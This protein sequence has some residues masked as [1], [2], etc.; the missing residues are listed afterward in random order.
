MDSERLSGKKVL[1]LE[2]DSFLH[3]LLANKMADLR[4]QGAEIFSALN[5]HDALRWMQ[6]STPDVI[7][8]D[9]IMPEMNGFDFL[10]SIRADDRF[11]KTQVVVLSNLNQDSD[12]KRARDLGVDHYYVKADFSLDDVM[13]VIVMLLK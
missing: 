11:K 8:L 7:L 2:D 6:A 13:K 4:K 3:T 10:E 1:I 12:K 5:A 9:L